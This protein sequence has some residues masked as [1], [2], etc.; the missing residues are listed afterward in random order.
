MEVVKNSHELAI[1]GLKNPV[2]TRISLPETRINPLKAMQVV[3]I[4]HLAKNNAYGRWGINGTA[5][6]MGTRQDCRLGSGWGHFKLAFSAF[7]RKI[8]PPDYGQ[9]NQTF[10]GS[11]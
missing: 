11:L 7:G 2:S 1:R 6:A 4:P 5:A 3:D 10:D 8:S 9:R